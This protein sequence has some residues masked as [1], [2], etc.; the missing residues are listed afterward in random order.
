[1]TERATAH[2]IACVRGRCLRETLVE[3]QCHEASLAALRVR[4]FEDALRVQ[5]LPRS[6]GRRSRLLVGYGND[7]LRHRAG[8]RSDGDDRE[9][10]CGGD[11]NQARRS[12]QANL[13]ANIFSPRRDLV[14]FRRQPSRCD[15]SLS[16]CRTC[17]T[18]HR[19]ASSTS[20]A[21]VDKAGGPRGTAMCS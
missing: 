9:A 13:L 10:A 11:T 20:L 6:L 17:Y 3:N 4:R 18:R 1:V 14:E 15:R 12:S 19:H 8:G 21:H 2:E 16:A 5:G 7:R